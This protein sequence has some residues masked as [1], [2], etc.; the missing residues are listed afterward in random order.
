MPLSSYSSKSN[1][2][3]RSLAF[4]SRRHRSGVGMASARGKP[5]DADPADAPR[6]ADAERS[7][8]SRA[9]PGDDDVGAL[10]PARAPGTSADDAQRATTSQERARAGLES[11]RRA[12]AAVEAAGRRRARARPSAHALAPRRSGTPPPRT[13]SRRRRGRA[14]RTTSRR[15][16]GSSLARVFSGRGWRPGRVL[17]HRGTRRGRGRRSRAPTGR[18]RRPRRAER[19]AAR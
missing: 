18:A 12:D 1:N 10:T 3:A 8:P 5:E 6:R 14:S 13:R 7:M 11:I 17:A 4:K 9:S 15:S 19:P 2:R 16:S